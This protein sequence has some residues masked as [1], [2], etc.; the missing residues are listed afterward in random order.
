[1]NQDMAYSFNQNTDWKNEPATQKQIRFVGR[2]YRDIR[3]TPAK[4]LASLT[5]KGASELIDELLKKRDI[6]RAMEELKLAR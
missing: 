6:H 5:R 1:M 3:Q 4:A 2:L